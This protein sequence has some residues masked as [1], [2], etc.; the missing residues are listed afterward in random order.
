MKQF[1]WCKH[2]D[3]SISG[4]IRCEKCKRKL[5]NQCLCC[6]NEV[7]HGKLPLVSVH[8]VHSGHEGLT[9]RQAAKL[10]KTSG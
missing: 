1:L 2:C 7:A 3:E 5:R 10:G 6:H 9:P 4:E 8:F